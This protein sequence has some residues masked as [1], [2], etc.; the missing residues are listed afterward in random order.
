M[1]VM[2]EGGGGGASARPA[3]CTSTPTSLSYKSNYGLHVFASGV[4][5]GIDITTT[6]DHVH[7]K[8]QM[9]T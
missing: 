3:C 4:A 1:E 2:A 8:D 9:P 7:T 5:G 6:P